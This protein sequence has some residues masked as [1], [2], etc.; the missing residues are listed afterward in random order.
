MVDLDS[1]SKLVPS[2]LV[3]LNKDSWLWHKLLDHTSIDLIGKLS[4]KDLVL[5]LPKL[6]YI[7]DKI[8]DVE[9]VNK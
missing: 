8:C 4:K 5:A 1:K 3:S 7:K 2:C 9:R 6:D